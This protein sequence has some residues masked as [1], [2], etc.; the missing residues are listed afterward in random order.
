VTTL[1]QVVVLDGAVDALAVDALDLA[2]GGLAML[3]R[4]AV[5]ISPGVPVGLDP[6][7]PSI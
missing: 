7:T 2:T 3:G 6:L 5:Q 4:H 1:Q